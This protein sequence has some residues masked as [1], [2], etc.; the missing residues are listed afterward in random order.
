M[1]ISN[2]GAIPPFIVMDVM[3]AAA[4]REAMGA[5]VL[6]LEVGQPSTPAPG[7][8]IAAAKRA[9]DG[10]LLGYT[11]A[12]G[13][14][15]L[16]QRIVRHYLEYYG[17]TL[18]PERICVTTGSSAAFLLTFLAAFDPGD[19]VAILRPGYPC[20][21]NILGALDIEAVEVPVG[22]DSRFQPT[23][24]ALDAAGGGDLD[25]LLIASPANPTGSM[26]R[27]G[28]L[29]A[30]LNYCRARNIRYISDEIYHQITYGGATSTAVAHDENAVVINSFS[31]Y[32]SMT[33]WR[34]GW[35]VLPE[36][37]LRPVERLAQNLF[38]SAPSLAQH[39]AVA[40]FDC[41]G[42]LDANVARYAR[43]RDLL[44]AE[45]P[46][47]GLDRFA[48]ADGAFYIYAD[49]AKFADDAVAFCAKMLA[50]TGVAATP[51]NDFDP[52]NGASHV[53]F[54]F[55]GSEDDMAEA[56]RRLRDWLGKEI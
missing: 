38:I 49:V 2:R 46:K 35:M 53:R 33:G 4:E 23:L 51:G 29:R 34:L 13:I 22:P 25:G 26:L 17:V 48:P 42:E 3:K 21:R 16:R 27:E 24:A 54:S 37:M 52:V 1:K 45:L 41:S 5:G 6:H 9:L 31:K 10:D 11:L 20:Y 56:C 28:E 18:S 50:Q 19:K 8:V 40:A 55:A 39:A 7:G 47:A 36:E 15:A 30:I 12:T 44:L 14:L 43:N 32:Y